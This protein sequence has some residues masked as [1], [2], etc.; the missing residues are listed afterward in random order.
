M[1]SFRFN[2]EKKKHSGQQLHNHGN[3]CDIVSS[4]DWDIQEFV[5]LMPAESIPKS[6]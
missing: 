6:D 2:Q 1:G 5:Y 4:Q 3:I